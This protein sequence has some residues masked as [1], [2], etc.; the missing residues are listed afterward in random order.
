MQHLPSGGNYINAW[1]WVQ[2][3]DPHSLHNKPSSSTQPPCSYPVL[4]QQPLNWTCFVTNTLN[5]S[6]DTCVT[7]FPNTDSFGFPWI[8]F[9]VAICHGSCF[10]NCSSIASNAPCDPQVQR[11]FIPSVSV[12]SLCCWWGGVI[13]TS[14]WGLPASTHSATWWQGS[15]SQ[16]IINKALMQGHCLATAFPNF[17]PTSHHVSPRGRIF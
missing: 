12:R 9:H 1:P 11:N 14:L 15:Q 4:L 8:S 6:A 17:F 7:R 16:R 13:I 10:I 3:T 5:Q 2:H